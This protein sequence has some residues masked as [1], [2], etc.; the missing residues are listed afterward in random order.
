MSRGNQ[1]QPFVCNVPK[2]EEHLPTYDALRDGNL[3]QYFQ[4]R[5]V[6]LFLHSMGW[7]DSEGRIMDLDKHKSKLA[8]IE[9]EF[10]AAEKMEQWRLQEE[11]E[12][13][14]VIFLKRQRAFEEAKRADRQAKMKQE[15]GLR[16]H[17]NKALSVARALPEDSLNDPGHG[18]LP[19]VSGAGAMSFGSRSPFTGHGV[20]TGN[21]DAPNTASSNPR[22][23]H[24][25]FLTSK[26]MERPTGSAAIARPDT[27][28][29]GSRSGASG[30]GSRS[31]HA[32]NSSGL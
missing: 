19:S 12:M 7:I 17:L 22:N 18:R 3:R 21:T 2:S 8:I 10:R 32:R 11:N 13:R 28:A 26:D 29:G 20:S 6:Q 5:N 24:A 15:R 4:S 14:R 31:Q 27:S 1:R 9:Q 16:Q 23:Y 25:T 30:G